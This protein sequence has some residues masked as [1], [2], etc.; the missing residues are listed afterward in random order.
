VKAA[1]QPVVRAAII[2]V[3]TRPF[4]ATV[5]ITGTLVSRAQVDVK[6]E[7]TGRV[8]KFVKQEGESVTAGEPL[9]WVNAEDHKLGVRQAETAVQVAEAGL[10]RA[11]VL[12]AH[13]KNELDRAN[14]LL[15]SGGITD[16]EVKAAQV[17]ELDA[18]A[19]VLLA[20]AQLAQAKAALEVARKRERDTTIHAPVSGEIQRRY[21]NPGAYVEPPTP[22]FAIVDNR[23]LELETL[24]PA[25]ELGGVHAGQPV[26][27]AVSSF[28][29]VAFT[30]RVIEVN[31]AV[32]A[33]TRSAR[34]RVVVNNPAGKLKAGMFS[35]GEIQTGV[36]AQ[37]VVVPL[38]AVYRDDQSS[39]K[40]F[41]FVAANGKAARRDI[42]LGRERD[43]LVQ[44]LEGLH[45]GDRLI[46]EQSIEIAEG[47]PVEARR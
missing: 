20:Q 47:V 41:V 5:A 10:E 33:N 4:T 22:V 35:E 46:A 19:Q 14:N 24:V 36:E 28:P 11:K 43:G 21:V 34:I 6:A 12:A 44:V 3:E 7:T 23:Q 9:V 29:G 32:D 31:P 38:A 17:A 30:G 2:S 18:K 8:M 39:H 25:A 42:T 1:S 13:N 37:A 15:T 26:N 16:R 45:R 40:S 27:F